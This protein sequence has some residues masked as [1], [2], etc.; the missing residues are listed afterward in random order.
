MKKEQLIIYA[1]FIAS[2]SSLSYEITLIRIFSIS[3]WYHF[4][5]MVISI[6]MLGIGASGTLLAVYPKL[7]D[8]RHLP[9]YFLMLSI[10]IPASYLLM[11][12]IPFEPTRLSWDR[13]QILYISLYYVLLALPFFSF[14]LI[15]ST[16]FSTMKEYTGYLYGADL[17]GAGTGSI[18]ILF[19]LYFAG[20][21]KLVFIISSLSILSLIIIGKK[22]MRLISFALLMINLTTLYLYPAFMH[23]KIS[24]YKPLENAMQFPGAEH[25][26]TY[27]SPFSQIDLFKSPAV[28]FAP[29]LSLKY[30]EEL[31][32]QTGISV[33][34]GDI[35]A[36][37]N[38]MDR[39]R[40]QFI[41]YLPASLP[42]EIFNGNDVLV[43]EPKGGLSVLT[44]QYYG[45]GNI[46]AAESNPDVVRVVKE[47]AKTFSSDIY[48]KNIWTGLGRSRLASSGKLFD[49]IDISMTGPSA[50]GSFG[51]SED[52]R[53]TVEAFQTYMDHLKPEG[54]LS[55]NLFIIPPP[56]T[57]L[58]LLNTIAKVFE[59]TGNMDFYKH[60]A[61][62]RTWG[63]IT[64][65]IR[66]T[67]FSQE[68]IDALKSFAREKRFDL[69][70]YPGISEKETNIYIKMPSNEYPGAFKS[71]IFS[72]TR[73][74]FEDS[75]LFDIRPVHDEN[76][77]FH[78]YLKMKNIRDIYKVM[79]NKWQY[80]I[81]EGYL[82]PLILVQTVILS[83][84]L[85]ILPLSRYKRDT[86][87]KS[88]SLSKIIIGLSYFA[89]LG[90]AF[91][92]VEVSFVQKMILLLENPSYAA[93]TVLASILISS[94]I[95][96]LLSQH[97]KILRKPNTLPI[98]FLIVFAYALLMPAV[99]KIIIPYSL[100]TKIILVFVLLMPVGILMGMPFPMGL[101]FLGRHDPELIL[102][103]WAV[104]GC[105]S[106]MSPILAIMLALSAGFKVVLISGMALYFLAFFSLK[107]SRISRL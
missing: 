31:P 23:L 25:I 71:L 100:N 40:L 17:I 24:P 47:Y 12:I 16:S 91:M 73:G 48:D 55:V 61:A 26:K 14:G 4:A 64:L 37:T 2:L 22:W 9:G 29:G 41:R 21:D 56:R 88:L 76:P 60:V 105:F 74:N 51:F 67:G 46:Y 82:L 65:L 13:V 59:K 42:Y 106:V 20:P 58:R 68:D 93:A 45:A 35:H 69:V 6:A 3:L 18:L 32:E 98:L 62:V 79:G 8:K 97:M 83:L 15:I 39:Q 54:V 27:Y 102:W 72:E 44:A 10:S 96:S 52:Y 66:K 7:K 94:G 84:L 89:I 70:Y 101:R 33:D 77:F 1:I 80:F 99:M 63:T 50:S 5:F 104:N 11:N 78:Y 81:E 53:F 38:D 90:I 107:I 34:Y 87:L 57:E 43:L 75:Y 30:L 95:G 85:I 103:A 49:I 86:A 19:L 36:I 92:F 28:R